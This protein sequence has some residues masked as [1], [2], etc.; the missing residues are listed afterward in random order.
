MLSKY[1]GLFFRKMK[2]YERAE[3]N[4]REA[5][6]IRHNSL[7]AKNG[8]AILIKTGYSGFFRKVSLYIDIARL[9]SC[10]IKNTYSALIKFLLISYPL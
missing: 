7:T 8:L 5:L 9:K 3:A 2:Q 6:K 1:K 4:Y 10:S